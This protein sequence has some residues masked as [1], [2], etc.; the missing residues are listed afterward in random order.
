[1][2]EK[3]SRI[4]RE[5]GNEGDGGEGRGKGGGRGEGGRRRAIRGERGSGECTTG[6]NWQRRKENK[7]IN[8]AIQNKW[9]G[10]SS[11]NERRTWRKKIRE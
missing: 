4:E 8:L 10:G 9:I 3:I 11:G 1:M 2:S 6:F 7:E 5:R